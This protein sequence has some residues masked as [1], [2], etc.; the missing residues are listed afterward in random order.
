MHLRRI[1]KVSPSPTN[2]GEC[3]VSQK[4]IRVSLS[5]SLPPLRVCLSCA[6]RVCVS[7]LEN[8]PGLP[9]LEA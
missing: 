4:I 5:L 1:G 8:W 6:R 9:T 7:A 3:D 2:S